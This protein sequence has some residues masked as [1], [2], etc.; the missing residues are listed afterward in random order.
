MI[1]FLKWYKVIFLLLGLIKYLN[2]IK[3]NGVYVINVLYIVN[4][5]I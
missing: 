4:V 2:C 3:W 1:Y 5:F